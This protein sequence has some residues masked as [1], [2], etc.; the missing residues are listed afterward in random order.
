MAVRQISE[1]VRDKRP[2]T[3]FEETLVRDVCQRMCDQRVGAVL[4]TDEKHRLV[5]VFTGRDAVTRVLANGLDPNSTPVR[6][7]M[8][9]DP[10]T[11]SSGKSAIEALRVMRDGGFRHL[12]VVDGVRIVSLISRGD[13]RGIEQAR[14]DEETGLWERI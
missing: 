3:V 6:N 13:F 1:M 7:V 9:P 14:L 4:V 5:G 12:P 2:I 8:S 11:L 10:V